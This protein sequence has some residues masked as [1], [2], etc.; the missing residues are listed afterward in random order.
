MAQILTENEMVCSVCEKEIV[1][2]RLLDGEIYCEDCFNEVVEI[3]GLIFFGENLIS[4][5]KN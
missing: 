2:G 3:M 5:E 4:V 1:G